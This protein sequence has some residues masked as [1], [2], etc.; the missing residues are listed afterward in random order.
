ML[1]KI[2]TRL[3][4]CDSKNYSLRKCE[5][6]KWHFAPSET[7]VM[8]P[9][10]YTQAGSQPLIPISFN[11][12]AEKPER[13]DSLRREVHGLMQRQRDADRAILQWEI[14]SKAVEGLFFPYA[15]DGLLTRSHSFWSPA[16]RGT[17][18]HLQGLKGRDGLLLHQ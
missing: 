12:I 6:V 9:R 11:Y 16:I 3:S 14:A 4:S 2:F 13:I 17:Q 8:P 5:T 18:C 7:F 15:L 1:P 10:T